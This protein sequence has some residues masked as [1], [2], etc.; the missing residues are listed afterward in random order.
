MRRLCCADK[1]ANR[2]QSQG[3]IIAGFETI[4]EQLAA[5]GALYLDS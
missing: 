5:K 2:C 4:F 1:V 3:D